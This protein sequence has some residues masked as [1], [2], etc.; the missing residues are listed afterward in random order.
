M[1]FSNGQYYTENLIN[2]QL[3]NKTLLSKKIKLIKSGSFDSYLQEFSD[4]KNKLYK[5]LTNVDKEYVSLYS[6]YI[7]R[8]IDKK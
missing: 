8:N 7:Y 6:F 5:Q 2:I 3:L 1:P 4:E